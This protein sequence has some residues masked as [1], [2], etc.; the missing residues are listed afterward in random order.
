MKNVAPDFLFYIRPS[1]NSEINCITLSVI[2]LYVY[3]LN[4]ECFHLQ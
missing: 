1:Y 3:Y 4:T 2:A